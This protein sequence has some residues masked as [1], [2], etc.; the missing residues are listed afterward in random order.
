MHAHLRDRRV[1]QKQ[2][3]QCQQGDTTDCKNTVGSELCFSRE[4]RECAQD[5]NQRGETGWQQI[6]RKRRDQY[7]NNADGSRNDGSRVVKLHI[8]RQGP[9]C[10]QKKRHIRIH[11]IRQNLLF[12]C[13]S[14][15]HNRVSGE[16]QRN[17]LPIESLECLALKLLQQILFVRGDVLDQ[18]LSKSFLVRERF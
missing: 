14:E 12:Q 18:V 1:H 6:Q 2:S 8:E 10:E 15:R 5:E 9:N 17:R 7:K 16:V 3:A 4:Q 11:Q 13:H